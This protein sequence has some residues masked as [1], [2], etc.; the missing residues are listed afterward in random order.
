MSGRAFAAVGSTILLSAPVLALL[1]AC[2]QTRVISQRQPLQVLRQ[3]Q[4]GGL[5]AGRSA[6][7]RD[8]R[9]RLPSIDE[10][11]VEQPDGSEKL[12][13]NSVRDLMLHTGRAIERGD[14]ELF[15]EQILSSVTRNEFVMRGRDPEEALGMLSRHEEGVRRLFERMPM[16]EYTPGLYL[17]QVGD[18]VYRLE[19]RNMPGG[20]R[21]TFI[22]AVFERGRW[23]LRWLGAG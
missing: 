11:V 15:A 22:D 17:R 20:A 12:I 9:A 2:Q 23:Y 7:Q 21:Y 1:G 4:G 8:E 18:N 10:L 13:V 6:Q 19:A 14:A 5:A 16:G 3:Q